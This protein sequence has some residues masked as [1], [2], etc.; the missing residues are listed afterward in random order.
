MARIGVTPLKLP[1]HPT[2]TRSPCFSRHELY[3]ASVDGSGKFQ[4]PLTEVTPAAVPRHQ[5]DQVQG[6][7]SLLRF[8]DGKPTGMLCPTERIN[9]E[10]GDHV[11]EIYDAVTE[12]RR[13]WTST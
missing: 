1:R 5:G 7:G 9:V 4:I 13:K 10:T 12:S 6:Q 8:V 11:V 3:I 2:S